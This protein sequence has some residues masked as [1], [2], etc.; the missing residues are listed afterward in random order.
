[1][2]TKQTKTGLARLSAEAVALAEVSVLDAEQVTNEIV[3]NILNADT[4]DEILAAATGG[5]VDMTDVPQTVLEFSLAKSRFPGLGAFAVVTS[6]RQDT[7]EKVVWTSGSTSV[8]AQLYAFQ[9]KGLLPV[10][11]VKLESKATASGND[12]NYLTKA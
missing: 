1:M 3:E 2:A 7:G 11:N 6:I 4:V 5:G 8:V 10:E 9:S 12:V